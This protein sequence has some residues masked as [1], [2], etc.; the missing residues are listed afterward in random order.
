LIRWSALQV[1]LFVK[2][3]RDS[4]EAL[5]N[6]IGREEKQTYGAN[7]LQALGRGSPNTD[8]I[9]H[10][11]GVVGIKIHLFDT[12]RKWVNDG[13]MENPFNCRISQVVSVMS[14]EVYSSNRQLK[15]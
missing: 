8:C 5:K 3:C 1:G 11:H 13:V 4:I 12:G 10:Q 14:Q 6:S 2:A 7:W 15:T 9:A